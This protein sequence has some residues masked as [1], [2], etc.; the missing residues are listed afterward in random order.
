[1]G[2]DSG[3][4]NLRALRPE[5]LILP[6][7]LPCSAQPLERTFYFYPC[8]SQNKFLCH[9]LPSVLITYRPSSTLLNATLWGLR[10]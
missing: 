3:E 5:K 4:P 10:D 2:R 8:L 6:P 7:H 1:M 9:V